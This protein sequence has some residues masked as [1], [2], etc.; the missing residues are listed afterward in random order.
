[1]PEII[2]LDKLAAARREAVAECP[3]VRF[4]GVD[5]TLPPE[6]PFAVIEAVGRLQVEDE[7]QRNSALAESMGDIAHALFGKD[8]RKF[9]DMGPSIPDITALLESVPAAYG[10][11]AEV[12][13]EPEP[14]KDLPR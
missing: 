10:M 14:V 5:F 1:M 11:G 6:M 8:Y 4:G 2:D 3:V 13:E 12:E 7:D 9:L